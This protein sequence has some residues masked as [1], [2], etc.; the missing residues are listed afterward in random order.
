MM[1]ASSPTDPV[2]DYSYDEKLEDKSPVKKKHRTSPQADDE[3]PGT[4]DT[5]QKIVDNIPKEEDDDDSKKNGVFE[6]PKE[7]LP[8]KKKPR[9][10]MYQV[11]VDEIGAHVIERGDTVPKESHLK[12]ISTKELKH[13]IDLHKVEYPIDDSILSDGGYWPQLPTQCSPISMENQYLSLFNMQYRAKI[14]RRAYK[15]TQVVQTLTADIA[16][17]KRPNENKDVY[18]HEMAEVPSMNNSPSISINLKSLY[19]FSETTHYRTC[20][21]M[22]VDKAPTKVRKS[23]KKRE[24]KKEESEFDQEEIVENLRRTLFGVPNNI[25]LVYD[26]QTKKLLFQA[27]TQISV[28]DELLCDYGLTVG[29]RI[30]DD[31]M[32]KSAN[33]QKKVR[34]CNDI[35]MRIFLMDMKMLADYRS[36]LE[37]T[38]HYQPH[39]TNFPRGASW[40]VDRTNW[41]VRACLMVLYFTNNSHWISSCNFALITCTKTSIINAMLRKFMHETLILVKRDNAKDGNVPSSYWKLARPPG[42]VF[43]STTGQRMGMFREYL[44]R[45]PKCGISIE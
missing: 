6:I 30:V 3:I 29:N 7:E 1:S 38:C 17:L 4:D 35:P 33:K 16:S 15:P 13:M 37:L 8:E 32:F 27:V 14:A 11:D 34:V 36:V 20:V 26:S 41:T 43:T 23:K 28:N 45:L 44:L 10:D 9:R 21:Y 39:Q 12:A 25:R 40:E 42:S 5:Q 24:E 2:S 31:K 22:Q 18:G 19:D